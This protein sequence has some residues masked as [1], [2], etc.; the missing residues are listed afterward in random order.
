MFQNKATSLAKSIVT[1]KLVKTASK[2]FIAG[3]EKNKNKQTVDLF[4]GM[5]KNM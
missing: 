3:V 4:K 1:A 5:R 2:G